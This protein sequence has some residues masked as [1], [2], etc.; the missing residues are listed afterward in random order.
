[1]ILLSKHELNILVKNYL[2][3]QGYY[4][5]SFTFTNEVQIKD[6]QIDY[7]LE[8]LIQK[9]MQ[10]IFVEQHLTKMCII[11]VKIHSH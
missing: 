4:H 2:A 9:G 5:T 1:M 3:E 7:N 11:P 6:I 8:D 10:Y